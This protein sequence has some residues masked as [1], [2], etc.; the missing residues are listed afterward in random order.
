M[1]TSAI[2]AFVAMVAATPATAN[3]VN[4]FAADGGDYS[5]MRRRNLIRYLTA[6]QPRKPQIALIGEAP[7]YRGMRLTGVPFMGRK[8]LREGVDALEMFGTARGYEPVQEPRWE[9]IDGEPS[10]TIFWNTLAELNLLPLVWSAY[11]F[12][13]HE[14]GDFLSNRAPTPAEKAIGAGILRQLLAIFTPQTVIA[15]GNVAHE[16]L[17]GLGISAIKVRHPSHGGKPEFVAGLRAF[18]GQ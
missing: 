4:P 9:K 17:T 14:A 7:G 5:A 3:S 16:T 11:P 12:H 18:L 1:T 10:G 13:P 8:M 2:D 6:L 15:V